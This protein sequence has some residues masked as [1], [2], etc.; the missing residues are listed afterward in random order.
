MTHL[1][2]TAWL[3]TVILFFI[4][5]KIKNKVLHQMI[6]LGYLSIL[7]TGGWMLL[8]MSSYPWE[9]I[10]KA[11]FGVWIIAVMEMIIIRNEKGKRT[12]GLWIQFSVVFIATVLL[13][14]YLPFG[15]HFS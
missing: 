7:F 10:V 1:H 12:Q 9:Y 5:I 15:F 11:I 3:L 6:R 2:I 13:G 14:L 4:A 8:Q